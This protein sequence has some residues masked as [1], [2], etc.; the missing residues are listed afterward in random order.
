MEAKTIRQFVSARLD[1]QKRWGTVWACFA[2]LACWAA[3]A[4]AANYRT[5][6][7]I[8]EAPTSQ[9]AQA[10][11]DA[12][13]KYRHDLASYWT[14]QPLAPWPTPC[15][16]RVVAGNLP[17]QGVTTYNPA[18]VR[19]FQMEVVGTPER[20]LDSVLPHE[21][22]HTVLATHF[23]RP[24]PRW[25]DEGICTTV[26][27]DSEKAKHEAKLREFLSTRRGIAM[28][29]LFLLTEYPSDVLP[30]YAQGYSVCRFLIE[31]QGPETF[32]DFLGE[33]MQ[34]GSWTNNVQKH[35]GYDSL[36]ELQ[37]YWLAWVESGSGPVAQFAKLT[38]RGSQPGSTSDI[39]LVSAT[40]PTR[41]VDS[42][43]SAARSQV[44]P[45][46]ALAAVDSM[47][48]D[49]GR[50]DSGWKSTNSMA[51]AG[52][53]RAA[54]NGSSSWYVRQLHRDEDRSPVESIPAGASA[55]IAQASPNNLSEDASKSR[56]MPPSVKSSGRYS[57]STPQGESSGSFGG[58]RWR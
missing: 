28:N 21:V 44:A 47:P 37:E 8:V 36:A 51:S 20:I 33:Y 53:P 35:Y 34:R 55:P 6:N 50:S 31:Q 11:G 39:A 25:A 19:D 3:P 12:A 30:M 10:V 54:S 58:N 45:A 18:P 9:L 43:N 16:V 42:A 24:L 27:H 23:G 56:W 13:E 29:Q 38:P 49:P 57:V 2:V 46:T 22:T 32:I 52:N 17:A 7:F 40:G 15:P 26:E 1:F 14:G 5:R 48:R 41:P 4:D